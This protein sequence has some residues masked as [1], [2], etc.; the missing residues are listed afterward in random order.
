[1]GRRAA[2]AGKLAGTWYRDLGEI[3]LAATF[4]GDELKLCMTQNAE[5]AEIC[6]TLTADY[7][8]TK[9]GLVHGVITG[10]DVGSK[11][12]PKLV[13]K[14]SDMPMAMELAQMAAELQ[15][16]VDCPFSFRIKQTSAG[17]MVSKLKVAAPKE[18][19]EEVF[20]LGLRHVQARRRRQGARAKD[21]EGRRHARAA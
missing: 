7:A 17:V 19:G 11:S 2:Q 10:I 15:E 13:R 6:I 12:D 9:E 20:A 3:V 16:V 4:S 14:A 21:S 18:M 5:G 8:I 1:M